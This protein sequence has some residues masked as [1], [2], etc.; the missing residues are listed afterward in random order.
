[1]DTFWTWILS[2]LASSAGAAA[3]IAVAAYLGRVQLSHWLSRDLEAQKAAHQRDL[4][5]YKVSL[6][7]EAEKAKASRDVQKAMAVRIAEKKFSAID[8]LHQKLTSRATETLSALQ[9]YSTVDHALRVK[10]YG[11][12]LNKAHD[13]ST[14]A[15]LASPFLT[16][17]ERADVHNF[18][19][20]LART[21]GRLK[22]EKFV[23]TA[24][25][26]VKLKDELIAMQT[27]CDSILNAHISRMLNMD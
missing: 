11:E 9:V 3:L 20:A 15:S 10:A 13:A 14:V 12:L 18:L 21:A 23:M 16:V 5:A 26:Q 8:S 1:M 22:E 7:A 6:I 27:K 4:E 19:A 24:D 2:V 25:E 17:E